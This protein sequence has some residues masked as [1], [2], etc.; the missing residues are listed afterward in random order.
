MRP[1]P[2]QPPRERSA[3]EPAMVAR[4]RRARLFVLLRR[5]RHAWCSAAFQAA[6]A[7]IFQ[8]RSPGQPPGPPAPLALVPLL[9]AY[10]GA[11]DDEALE[12]LTMDRR[13]PLVCDG[14]DGAE[15]P[16]RQAPLVRCRAARIAHGLDRRLIERPVELAAR[17]GGFGP[18]QRR[19]AL[20]SSPWGA[21][22]GARRRLIFWAPLCAR[23]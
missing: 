15:P 22:A 14:L 12:A 18:R 19:A 10:P 23:P 21:R 17:E 20:D 9:P 3:A 1:P 6:L 2:W 11:S 5:L 16:L 8:E 13:W 4:I 7:R